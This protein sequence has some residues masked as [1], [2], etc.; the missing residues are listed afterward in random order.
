MNVDLSQ[1]DIRL[2]L[3]K[4]EGDNVKHH[5]LIGKLTRVL[6][7]EANDDEIAKKWQEWQKPDK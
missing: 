7:P 6:I 2:M 1:D 5:S 3:E 4:L